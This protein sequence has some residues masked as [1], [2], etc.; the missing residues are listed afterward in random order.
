MIVLVLDTLNL[1]ITTSHYSSTL[2][3]RGKGR[4]ILHTSSNM[5]SSTKE[6]SSLERQAKQSDD[7][8]EDT[9]KIKESFPENHIEKICMK[10][11]N[12]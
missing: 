5:N 12:Y 8:D 3:Q 9:E 2:F 10:C 4:V 7:D 1:I 6:R 11:E